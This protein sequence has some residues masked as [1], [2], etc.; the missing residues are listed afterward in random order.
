MEYKFVNEIL[1]SQ[2]PKNLILGIMFMGDLN[3]T[4]YN[5]ENGKIK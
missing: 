2:L 4:L 5:R 3:E 1:S